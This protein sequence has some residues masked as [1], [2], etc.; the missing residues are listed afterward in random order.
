MSQTQPPLQSKN[1]KANLRLWLDPRIVARK[2]LMLDDTPRSIALG[3]AIGVFVA[4]TPTVGIQMVLVLII[5]AL[6][7]P[8]FRF[9][10]IAG[11]VAV[12]ISNPITTVPIYWFCYKLGTVFVEGNLTQGAF[13]ELLQY[14]GVREYCQTLWAIMVQMGW[15][16][17][18]GSGIVATIGAIV[19]F[20]ITFY[21]VRA[22]QRTAHRLAEAKRRL[23]EAAESKKSHAS[24]VVA[25]E[26]SAV[27]ANDSEDSPG[28]VVRTD[29]E[30]RTEP[31]AE[32]RAENRTEDSGI[33][34]AESA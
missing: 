22:Y 19:S 1:W 6:C 20:P 25:N 28:P 14:E 29:I 5:A 26:T 10:Q 12:Y 27:E 34:H 30:A 23:L 31:R 33:T 11:L 13:A 3:T 7:R 17:I 24:E 18:V 21:S 9:N 2:I 32:T 4:L 16:L 15:P 8:F